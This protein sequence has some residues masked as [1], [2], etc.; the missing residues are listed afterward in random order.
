MAEQNPKRRKLNNT[1]FEYTVSLPNNDTH[2][3]NIIESNTN[4]IG[5]MIMALNT[6]IDIH[7]SKTNE[8][9]EKLDFILQK[10][11]NLENKM[12]HITTKNTQLFYQLENVKRELS[13]LQIHMLHGQNITLHTLYD[14]NIPDNDSFNY[15]A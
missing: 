4:K 13:D 3:L 6:K 1:E 5:H 7:I 9:I 10:I 12:E 2:Q 15:C 14:T 11:L 8:N